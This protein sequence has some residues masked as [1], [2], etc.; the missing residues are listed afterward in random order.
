MKG[1]VKDRTKEENDKK[2]N[3]KCLDKNYVNRPVKKNV[4]CT[5]DVRLLYSIFL[6]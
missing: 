2:R 4:A 3:D 1:I 6:Q 5:F